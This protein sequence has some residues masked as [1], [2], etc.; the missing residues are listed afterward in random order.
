MR[1]F[2][3][4]TKAISLFSFVEPRSCRSRSSSISSSSSS[5]SSSSI[6]SSSSSGSSGHSSSLVVVA[7]AVV[8]VFT[9]FPGLH[10]PLLFFLPWCN[11]LQVGSKVT[12]HGGRLC[13]SI[14]TD[15]LLSLVN[16]LQHLSH[17]SRIKKLDADF[18][19][20]LKTMR[21]TIIHPIFSGR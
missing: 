15:L 10:P 3:P 11:G 7:A 20:T 14:T 19:K 2:Q 16:V 18:Q 8:I 9:L 17:V 5:S 4:R 21:A 1:G 6:T 13:D 12:Q